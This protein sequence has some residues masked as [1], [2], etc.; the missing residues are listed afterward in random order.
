MITP[1]QIFKLSAVA[2]SM[3]TSNMLFAQAFYADSKITNVTVYSDQ[4]VVTRQMTVK[5]EP[6]QSQVILKNLPIDI[7]GDSFQISQ[8]FKN[9][10][11]K[12]VR[13]IDYQFK[14]Q[15][16]EKNLELIELSNQ[17]QTLE[18]SYVEHA[19]KIELL[20]QKINFIKEVIETAK[21]TPAGTPRITREEIELFKQMTDELPQLQLALFDANKALDTFKIDYNIQAA[22]IK[23][24]M[25]ALEQQDTKLSQYLT[26]DYDVKEPGELDIKVIYA[27]NHASWQPIYELR[28]NENQLDLRYQ[29]VVQQFTGEDWNK[30]NLALSTTPPMFE[31]PS[32]L[33]PWH[34]SLYKNNSRMKTSASA[35]ASE[36]YEE[37]A[38]FIGVAAPVSEDVLYDAAPASTVSSQ[39][40]NAL[41]N[42]GEAVTVQGD[43]TPGKVLIQETHFDAGI[44]REVTP[45]YSP[46][47]SLFA[48][49]ENK[50]E[51]PWLAGNLNIFIEDEFISK[52]ML[53]KT[54][55]NED[56]KLFLGEDQNIIVKQVQPE[57]F[58]ETS[59]S[60]QITT[61]TRKT[62][63]QSLHSIPVSVIVNQQVPVTTD[64]KIKIEYTLIPEWLKPFV[65][66]PAE[67]ADAKSEIT[68]KDSQGILKGEI[69]LQPKTPVTYELKYKVTYPE[70]EAVIGF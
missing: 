23:K 3:L 31:A 37:Q 34:L 6:G 27:V 18:K 62:T 49:I 28:L 40:V 43:Y 39:G 51:Y 14:E 53:P 44:T 5:V 32:E 52:S 17:L 36:A 21:L 64:E 22:N 47:V 66:F 8:S 63:L 33:Y 46:S 26:L 7:K 61:E 24:Q 10:A 48:N 65:E 67:Q 54:Q 45:N 58:N 38:Q 20:E 69:E 15:P 25:D 70:K 56:L 29:A 4:A 59:W 41:F 12:P 16:N 35:V 1:K 13:F 42:I 55:V 50:T 30:V 57:R 60:N 19:N 11:T 68:L 2:I 9:P